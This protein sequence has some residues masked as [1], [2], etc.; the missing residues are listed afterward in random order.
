MAKFTVRVELHNAD[1]S[2]YTALHEKMELNNFSR[3]IT[4]SSG[5][6]YHLPEAEYDYSSSTEDESDVANKARKIAD[7]IKAKSGIFVT[8]SAGRAMRGL[9]EV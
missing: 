6:T 9:K 2:D 8:K 7:S 4:A 1:S 5:T 3:E